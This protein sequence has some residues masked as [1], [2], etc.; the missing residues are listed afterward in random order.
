MRRFYLVYGK[1]PDN[2]HNI[3][4]QTL[5]AELATTNTRTYDFKLS[6]SHYMFLMGLDDIN[7]RTFYEIEAYNNN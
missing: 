7:E 5:S 6:W 3:K 1:L 2:K 4:T